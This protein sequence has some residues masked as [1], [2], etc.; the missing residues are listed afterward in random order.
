MIASWLA[1]NSQLDPVPAEPTAS[2]P[3][4]S[5]APPVMVVQNSA[6][7]SAVTPL[8]VSPPVI[9]RLVVVAFVV[10]A[11]FAVRR[12]KVDD[13]VT[14]RPAVVEVGVSAPPIKLNVWPKIE[15]FAGA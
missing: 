1:V 4:Q 8:K 2:T 7:V 15:W 3:S 10:V 11:K 6:H 13:A 5:P 9:A 14:M 12:S